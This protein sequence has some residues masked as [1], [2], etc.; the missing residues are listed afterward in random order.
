MD[1]FNAVAAKILKDLYEYFPAPHLPTPNSI[2]LT[3]EDPKLI[4][5]RENTSDE[6]KELAKEL[7]SALLWLVEEGYVSDRGYQIGPSHVLTGNG[8]KALQK[9]APEYKPPTLIL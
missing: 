5:G 8:L 2:G 1:R 7:R 3:L 6:Y 9:I 4:G